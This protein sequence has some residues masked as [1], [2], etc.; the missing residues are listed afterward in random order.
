M[1]RGCPAAVVRLLLS[2][3]MCKILFS[4]Y[5]SKKRNGNPPRMWSNTSKIGFA[6]IYDTFR[7][8]GFSPVLYTLALLDPYIGTA[9]TRFHQIARIVSLFLEPGTAS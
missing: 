1:Q 6:T 3:T 8:L 4:G 9:V 7:I 5:H 2:S